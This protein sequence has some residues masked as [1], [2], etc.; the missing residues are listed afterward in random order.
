MS[1]FRAI[2][3]IVAAL[4]ACAVASPATASASVLDQKLGHGLIEL[5]ASK[6]APGMHVAATSQY[7]CDPHSDSLPVTIICYG[8]VTYPG[9]LVGQ[10]SVSAVMVGGAASGTIT[11]SKNKIALL[12]TAQQNTL[13][14]QDEQWRIATSEEIAYKLGASETRAYNNYR[15]H[16]GNAVDTTNKVM[17]DAIKRSHSVRAP[18]RKLLLAGMYDWYGQQAK[19]HP[20]I[21]KE[22]ARWEGEIRKSMAAVHRTV[23]FVRGR[24][25]EETTV[26]QWGF[27]VEYR[28]TPG[29]VSWSGLSTG[30][31]CS[32]SGWTTRSATGP[33]IPS[34]FSTC[35]RLSRNPWTPR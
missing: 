34:Y 5:A 30:G 19:L 21:N 17:A 25:L 20:E 10:C 8:P 13:D 4:A 3:L 26:P 23:V 32:L 11:C 14:S 33:L 2:H 16:G 35:V 24:V 9:R 12:Q 18:G 7:Q 15:Q 29:G 28:M 1:T 31:Q 27:M 6:Y 22:R